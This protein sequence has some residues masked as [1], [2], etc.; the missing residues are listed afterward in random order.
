[1]RYFNQWL[2]AFLCAVFGRERLIQFKITFNYGAEC[3]YKDVLKVVKCIAIS[4]DQE[5]FPSI[6]PGNTD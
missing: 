4:K 2:E 6:A 5:I 3:N 1:M